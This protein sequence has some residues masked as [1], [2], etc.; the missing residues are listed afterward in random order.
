VPWCFRLS[1]SRKKEMSVSQVQAVIGVRHHATAQ[2][3]MED[4]GK[5]RVM[6]YVAGGP[7]RAALL[8]FRAEWE[9][10]TEPEFQALLLG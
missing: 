7:G 6:E 5:Q 4:L 3:V 2:K 9:W 8:R 10:C 1:F